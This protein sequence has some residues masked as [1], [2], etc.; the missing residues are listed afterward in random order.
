M[1]SFKNFI[2]ESFRP[3]SVAAIKRGTDKRQKIPKEGTKLRKYYDELHSEKG[4]VFP[5]SQERNQYKRILN[6]DY[7]IDFFHTGFNAYKV[8]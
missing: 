2:E 7:G 3:L 4:C 8:R 6:D 1:I 5:N